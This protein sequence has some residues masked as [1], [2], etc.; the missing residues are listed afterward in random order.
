MKMKMIT[1]NRDETE[2]HKS[3]KIRRANPDRKKNYCITYILY[4]IN[5]LLNKK[6]KQ[7]KTKP[8]MRGN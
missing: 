2:N 6:T 1:I 7:N 3:V 4:I 5:M 8:R